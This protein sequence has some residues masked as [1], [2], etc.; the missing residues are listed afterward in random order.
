M[1]DGMVAGGTM[2]KERAKK[3]VLIL[4]RE[5]EQRSNGDGN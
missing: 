4:M 3:T 1:K 2:V 5:F